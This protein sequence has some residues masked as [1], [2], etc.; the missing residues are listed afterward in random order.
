MNRY[1]YRAGE[2]GIPP[3]LYAVQFFTL[4]LPVTHPLWRIYMEARYGTEVDRGEPRLHRLSA[5]SPVELSLAAGF[6][7]YQA[8][9][10]WGYRCVEAST[11]RPAAM[12]LQP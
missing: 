6:G 8:C 7:V 12:W 2:E 5:A 11:R 4:L 10:L 9:Q 3:S 1:S